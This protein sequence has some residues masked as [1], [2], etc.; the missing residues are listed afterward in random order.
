ME[1]RTKWYSD[2]R[3]APRRARTSLKKQLAGQIVLQA[4][5]LDD[6]SVLPA[7]QYTK[8]VFSTKFLLFVI[9]PPLDSFC[10]TRSRSSV[11]YLFSVLWALPPCDVTRFIRR[12]NTL[13]TSFGPASSQL[14]SEYQPFRW[15]THGGHWIHPHLNRWPGHCPR[16][17]RALLI[18]PPK[19]PKSRAETSQYG[20]LAFNGAWL[21]SFHTL[22]PALHTSRRS[23]DIIAIL[24]LW[25][26]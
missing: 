8:T 23:P 12:M 22:G 21:D 9:I 18:P 15:R 2:Q 24:F 16:I 4:L 19:F 11:F 13:G 3:P 20:V 1:G 10:T 6:C 5:L 7:R 26:D 25:W 14:Q 17:R